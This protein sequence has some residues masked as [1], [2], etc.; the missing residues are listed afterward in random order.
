[1]PYFRTDRRNKLYY[2]L[3]KNPNVSETL[4]FLHGWAENHKIWRYQVEF[5]KKNYQILTLD[6]RGFGL[7]SKPTYGYALELQSGYLY[8]LINALNLED[9]WLIGHSLGGMLTLQFCNKF[10]KEING[11]ILIGTT[12]YFP[13]KITTLGHLGFFFISKSLRQI[14]QRTLKSI[15]PDHQRNIIQDLLRDIDSV[16]LYVS[17]ACGFAVINF[18]VKLNSI[19]CPIL[20]IIGEKDELIPPELSL[21]MHQTLPNSQ[22]SIIKNTGHMSFIEKP[23]KIN[24][25]LAQFLQQ[26]KSQLK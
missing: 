5:F 6:L 12:S 9:Y 2:K 21:R 19:I 15:Q 14:W 24:Q 18:K 8:K 10:F 7:S 3:I 16:P 1:M 17:A 4:I 11:A 23:E 22:I 25:I 13:K 26:T 20:I